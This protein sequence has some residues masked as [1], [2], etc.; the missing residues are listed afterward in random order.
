[1]KNKKSTLIYTVS[2]FSERAED[3]I[4]LLFDNIEKDENIDF[5][6]ISNRSNPPGFKYKT[7]TV[8]T[9]SN[10]IG[11]L[12]YCAKLPDADRYLYLDSDILF[13]G[14]VDSVFSED[15]DLSVV[16]ED[17]ALSGEWFSYHVS[18]KDQLPSH[19]FGLN[20][21]T[22]A[23]KDKKFLDRVTEKINTHFNPL[24]SPHVNAMLEQ[25]L[26]NETVGETYNYDWS[27]VNDLTSAARLY[28]PD[29][30]I[31]DS[32]VQIYH[33]CGW[34]GG[35]GSKY[36]RMK[37]FL[38]KKVWTDRGFIYVGGEG[39]SFTGES[40]YNA[41]YGSGDSF[42][43]KYGVTGTIIFNNETFGDPCPGIPKQAYL[44]IDC[45]ILKQLAPPPPMSGFEYAGEEGSCYS[46]QHVYDAAY[47]FGDNF[48]YKTNIVGDIV[49]N[50]RTFGGDPCYSIRKNGYIFIKSRK[51]K[52]DKP[53]IGE[54]IIKIKC[55]GA[56]FDINFSSCGKIK[57]VDFSWSDQDQGINVYIDNAIAAGIHHDIKNKDKAFGWICE[58]KMIAPHI[59]EDVSANYKKYKNIYSK[60][61][62]YDEELIKLDPE[63]FEYC[64]PGSNY[65]WTPRDEF[66]I[67]GK[68]KLVSFLSSNKN[69]CAGHSYR[70]DW[71]N[72]LNGLVDFYGG[73]MGSQII[74]GSH[75]YHHNKKT[76]AL[77]DYM[78]SIVIENCKIDTYF[79]E[80]VT[81]CFANGTIPVYFG[82]DNIGSIF[83]K[84]GIIVL[85]DNFDISMLT[86]ELY[87][88]K[89]K[90][91][92]NN[93]EM[94]KNM[95]LADD[96]L[97]KKIIEIENKK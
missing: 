17:F 75:S 97:Y 40:T 41:A 32:K 57:P 35:M 1:M 42:K 24:Y 46:S 65:P 93:L 96:M 88:S 9:T 69:T 6:V 22:F 91:I 12:K 79:T 21:G 7:I 34:T 16:V 64:F 87:Y 39:F 15:F 26:F 59:T 51:H 49:F 72:R 66:G 2:D 11:H 81:D 48:F 73:V 80:K 37:N 47:G 31:Y 62:T 5:C 71:A 3:C 30:C 89:M 82:T 68:S 70:L 8:D 85:N 50:N 55:F 38:E 86:E 77:K 83:D 58:S 19:V 28:V 94:V 33:F 63:F 54:P 43:Y 92:R 95:P 4:N 78:F 14:S 45:G 13:F 84:D 60:I 44:S 53:I 76:E 25:S 67:H 90:S 27:L 23:F 20:G 56:P 36:A 61:F 74:G 52:N 10:Y 18:N 29:N